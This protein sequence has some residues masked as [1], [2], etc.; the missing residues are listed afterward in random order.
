MDALDP[1]LL[2]EGDAVFQILT[3]SME[4][5]VHAFDERSIS[6]AMA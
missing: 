2:P 6:V 1:A 5:Y 3:D 4:L